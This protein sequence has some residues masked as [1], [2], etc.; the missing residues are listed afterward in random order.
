MRTVKTDQTGRA[1]AQADL[2][3][4]LAHRSFCC[5]YHAVAHMIL[6]V[7]AAFFKYIWSTTM[8]HAYIQL[9]LFCFPGRGRSS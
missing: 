4:L 8:L 1:D 3:L 6:E 5:F 7:D 9:I 2:S